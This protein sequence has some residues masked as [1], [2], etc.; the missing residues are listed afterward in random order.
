MVHMHV[1]HPRRMCRLVLAVCVMLTWAAA[2]PVRASP[3]GVDA[4]IEQYRQSI[5]QIMADSR[6]PGVSVALVDTDRV[7]WLQGFGQTDFAHGKPM[8]VPGIR[9]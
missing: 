3:D 2:P 9:H 8:N 1:A 5:P 4:A 7:L 6:I